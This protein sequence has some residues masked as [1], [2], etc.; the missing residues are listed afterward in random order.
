MADNCSGFLNG[1]IY[2]R[3]GGHFYIRIVGDMPTFRVS[4]FSKNSR[5]GCIIWVKNS[6][7]GILKVCDLPELVKFILMAL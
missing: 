6:R 5:T 1:V 3:G 4:I 7:T 2:T